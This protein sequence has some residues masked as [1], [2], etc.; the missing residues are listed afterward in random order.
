[1]SFAVAS[2]F[3][4]ASTAK[5]KTKSEIQEKLKDKKQKKTK[6]EAKARIK[7]RDKARDK[8]RQNRPLPNDGSGWSSV[9]PPSW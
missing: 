8:V 6:T 9:C 5:D 2:V 7:D 4:I 1:L 3:G